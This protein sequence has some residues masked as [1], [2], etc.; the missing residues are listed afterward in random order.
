MRTEFEKMRSGLLA[1][2]SDPALRERL[3]RAKTLIHRLNS[4]TYLRSPQYRSVISELLPHLP[5]SSDVCPPF[6]CDYGD[7]III[8]EHTFINFNCTFLDGGL[9]TIGSYVLIGPGVQIYTPHHPKDFLQRRETKETASPVTIGDDCWIGGG[10]II[11]PG[12]TIGDRCIIGAGS[13]VTKDVPSDTT[14]AGNPARKI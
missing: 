7:G 1:D 5:Q 13:V 3:N 6:F 10:A 11:L 9:I 4:Q 14:V 12:V 2:T 8:G